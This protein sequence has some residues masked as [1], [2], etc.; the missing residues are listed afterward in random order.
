MKDVKQNQSKELIVR[1]NFWITTLSVS[2]LAASLLSATQASAATAETSYGPFTSVAPGLALGVNFA[3]ARVTNPNFTAQSNEGLIFGGSVEL[4]IN[5]YLYIQP[6][7]NYVEKGF[8]FVSTVGNTVYTQKYNYNYLSIPVL[9]KAKFDTGKFKP[10]LVAGPEISF[11]VNANYSEA[12]QNPITQ[13]TLDIYSSTKSLELGLVIGA[14]GEYSIDDKLTAT[15]SIRY[16]HGLT[17]INNSVPGT[18]YRSEVRTNG[19]QLLVGMNY[20]L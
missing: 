9:A 6:E 3:N 16:D 4:G 12:T 5:D 2:F 13:R 19:V 17:N 11:L 14:G 8:E 15:G 1:K 18:S 10:L 7:V 20:K